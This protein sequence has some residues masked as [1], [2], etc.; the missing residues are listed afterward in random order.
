VKKAFALLALIASLSFTCAV[1]AQ[2]EPTTKPAKGNTVRGKVESIEGLVIT[3]KN[4]NGEATITTDANTTF[5][6]NGK[7]TTDDGKAFTIA[8]VKEGERLVATPAEGTAT[9]VKIMSGGKK[10]APATAPAAN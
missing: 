3:V 6:V 7:T 5:T 9:A 1:M 8:D 4:K 10:K 2:Q